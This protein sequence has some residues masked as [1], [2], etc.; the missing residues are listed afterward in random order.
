MKEI[1]SNVAAFIEKHK[2]P[3]NRYT[4]LFPL[5]LSQEGGQV[6]LSAASIAEGQPRIFVRKVD[7]S[8]SQPLVV[9]YFHDDSD[10]DDFNPDAYDITRISGFFVDS[11]SGE[12]VYVLSCQNDGSIP[13]VEPGLTFYQ[14]ESDSVLT[15]IAIFDKPAPCHFVK[16]D[17]KV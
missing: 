9:E 2:L 12:P 4:H 17:L 3:D 10:D 15:P 13:R 16:L 6:T 5:S 1:L 14:L 8:E 7:L 11:G